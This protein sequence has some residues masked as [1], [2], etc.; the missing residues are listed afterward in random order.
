MWIH[1]YVNTY[2]LVEALSV[3]T[4]FLNL[5]LEGAAAPPPDTLPYAPL[6]PD[7]PPAAVVLPAPPHSWPLGVE[8]EAQQTLVRLHY[9]LPLVLV[10]A[11][12]PR[13]HQEK[14][15]MELLAQ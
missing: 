14:M 11:Q 2:P 8:V 6:A 1:T 13:V 15:S 3:S 12:R 10:Q 5:R 9:L 7:H 4:T